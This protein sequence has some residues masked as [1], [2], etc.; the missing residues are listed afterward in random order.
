MTIKKPSVDILDTDVLVVGGGGA[1]MMAALAVSHA[2]LQGDPG[3]QSDSIQGVCDP[4]GQTD[5]SCRTV[6]LSPGFS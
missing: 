1:G 4:D 6:V 2:G 5:G 3:G